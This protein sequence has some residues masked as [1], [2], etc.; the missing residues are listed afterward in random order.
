MGK[1]KII[2]S[3]KMAK[4]IESNDVIYIEPESLWQKVKWL[5]GD[6]FS[7]EGYIKKEGG[8]HENKGKELQNGIEASKQ[9]Q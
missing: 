6:Y 5:F 7:P 4:L 9:V 1:E 2:D 3:V 8:Q